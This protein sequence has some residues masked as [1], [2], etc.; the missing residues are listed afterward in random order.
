MKKYSLVQYYHN[1]Q[2]CQ[3]DRQLKLIATRD[4]ILDGA[5]MSIMIGEQNEK[6]FPVLFVIKQA[7]NHSKVSAS[8]F[9]TTRF[10]RG[11]V[12]I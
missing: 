10:H 1:K 12:S 7:D 9:K 3:Y 2:Q 8:T 6:I 5:S 11:P 4:V